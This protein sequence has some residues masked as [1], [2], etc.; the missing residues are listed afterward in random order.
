MGDD[1]KIADVVEDD[2]NGKRALRTLLLIDPHWNRT[3]LI[4]VDLI[5]ERIIETSHLQIREK[6]L[7]NEIIV[8]VEAYKPDK[9]IVDKGGPLGLGIE[10]S[11][12]QEGLIE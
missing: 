2:I 1:M 8:F 4:Q 5:S 9:I 10:E 6:D 12:R 11:L 3:D 7:V